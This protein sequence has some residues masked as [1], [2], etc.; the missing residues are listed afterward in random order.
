MAVQIVTDECEVLVKAA[1]Q[2]YIRRDALVG[3]A[4]DWVYLDT[5]TS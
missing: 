2:E 1:V 3:L 5:K 4:L